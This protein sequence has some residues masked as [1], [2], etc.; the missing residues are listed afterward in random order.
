MT[1][2]V[3][4]LGGKPASIRCTSSD[5]LASIKTRIEDSEGIPCKDHRLM[6]AG[7]QLQDDRT[8]AF[9]NIWNEATLHLTSRVLGGL[10]GGLT[11]AFADVTDSS[12]SILREFSADVPEWNVV[13]K[14]L[15]IAGRCTN[16]A[17]RAF[18]R[19]VID[20]KRFE[21]FNV[22]LDGNVACPVCRCQVKP[23]LCGF[24]DCSWRY[25]GVKKDCAPV[26]SPWMDAS[27]RTYHQFK[28]D[29]KKGSVKWS[30]LVLVVK[31]RS[32]PVAASPALIEPIQA[33]KDNV[34][35]VCYSPLGFPVKAGT[36]TC[37][38]HKFHR[39]C[40]KMWAK[41]RKTRPS[42]TMC[43]RST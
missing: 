43:R 10:S 17:C 14:G 12:I 26:S 38:Y 25:E 21:P 7:K 19:T 1:I 30:S 34:C 20:P 31:P 33:N 40:S 24:Y 6:Y 5:T 23:V 18:Q 11:R 29:E 2:F 42:C 13:S 32:K 15:N 3:N 37:R 39:V 28:A 22:I 36:A 16:Q 27:G 8:M 9:Y 35:S 4:T 41:V